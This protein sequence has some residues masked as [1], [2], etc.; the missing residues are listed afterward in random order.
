MKTAIVF[1]DG[2][3][4]IIFTPENDDE[5]AALRHFSSNDRVELAVKNGDFYAREEKVPFRATVQM[6]HGGFLRAFSDRDSIM[7]VL[8]PR[9]DPK[10]VDPLRLKALPT[11]KFMS[12]EGKVFM[13]VPANLDIIKMANEYYNK[14]L[15]PYHQDSLRVGFIHG[16]EAILK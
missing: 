14:P 6:C 2:I 4:Q 1:A 5:R 8:S 9:S 15:E 7:F 10:E 16:V 13:E 12:G 3:K 11:G